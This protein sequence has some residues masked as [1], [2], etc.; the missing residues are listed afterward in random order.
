MFFTRRRATICIT[1]VTSIFLSSFNYAFAQG[2]SASQTN[3]SSSDWSRV[4][5][6]AIGSKLAVSAKAGTT[7]DGKLSSVSD[8]GLSI[9]VKGKTVNLR[10]E[11]VQSVYQ[12]VRKSAAKSTLI[13]LGAGAGAG[14]AVG[15][16]ADASNND[17]AFEKID[18]VAVAGLTVAGAA[19]GAIAGYFIG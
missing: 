5:S 10:R 6:V 7:F 3:Q 14:A 2:A 13:G 4:K 19:A 11:D 12:M 9:M 16:V 17:G 8:D 1:L 18:N 15:A